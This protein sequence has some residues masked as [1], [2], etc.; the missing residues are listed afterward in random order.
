MSWKPEVD[1]L[2]RRRE[3][4]ER[5]GGPEGVE[6]QHRQGKMTIR[7]RLELLVDPDS[8]QEMGKLQGQAVYGD[9][10]ELVDFTPSGRV[11][12]L[13]RVNSR[14]V[15][16]TGQDFTVRGGSGEGGG[17]GVDVGHGHPRPMEL[18]LPT[19]NL[20]DG[21]GG[22]VTGFTT[23]GRTYIP[24]GEFF[25]A[26]C[27]VLNIAPVASAV[28][29]PAAGGLAPMPCLAHFSVIVQGT[30]QVF[31]GGPPVVQAA[32]GDRIDKEDLGGYRIHTQISGVVDNAAET[33]ADAIAQVQ[34]FLSYMPDNV[35]E[36]PPRAE[37][38]D[39][40][41]RRDERLLSLIPRDRR[42]PYDPRV[43][44][45]GVLDEDSFFEIAPDYGK[46][47]IV[48]LARAD[49]YPVGVMLNNPNHKGGSMDV[50]AAEKSARLVQLC[51]TF[52]LPMV[53]L[54]DDPG[55]MVGLES[56]KQGIERAGTR[57]VY[58][59]T[60]SKMPWISF[61][62]RQSYGL[63]GSLQYRPG[64]HL[65]RRYAWPSGHWGSMHIEGGTSAAFRREI[66]AAPDPDEKRREL[67]AQ[68]QAL[69]SPF[70]TAEATG[71]D[72]IDPRETRAILCDFV[73][74]AQNVI[75]TQLGPGS[76][77]TYRP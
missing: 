1:E 63:A 76:G 25:G 14:R 28:L 71:L 73:E 56:E 18:R 60:Q 17:G 39:D 74:L 67:E 72:L 12:G 33:E 8:F 29:G 44:L 31:P 50:P 66:E 57:L 40:P 42:R 46:S 41:Q 75:K 24:D 69:S 37:P 45:E 15:Y 54:M 64:P 59:I 10:G 38:T 9:D 22:S 6:R 62:C 30:G 19:V 34:A 47:R 43:I 49:G 48:G 70:R 27:D 61:I 26:L 11:Y 36:M 4:A 32:L 53:V 20:L 7:E 23:L 68:F 13:A 55:F 65:Y 52:H 16:V 3:L 58:A 5:M 21:A 35:W 77:P 51:D 2:A